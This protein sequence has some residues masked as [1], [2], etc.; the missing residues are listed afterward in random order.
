MNFLKNNI[1]EDMNNITIVS[2]G[3]DI[4]GRKVATFFYNN[5]P[6][7]RRICYEDE[8]TNEL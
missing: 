7:L 1:I 6:E 8:L 4:G 5:V 3:R 2:R